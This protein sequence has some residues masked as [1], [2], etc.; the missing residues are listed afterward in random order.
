MR[1]S[2]STC[3]NW[4]KRLKHYGLRN[5][6][7]LFRNLKRDGCFALRLYKNDFHLR[8]NSV[9]FTVFDSIFAGGEYDFDIDFSPE[10]IIDAG[11]YIGASTIYFHH[12]FPD[13][14]ITAVEPEQTNFDLLA[15]N[16]APYKNL[17]LV[18]GAVYGEDTRLK[19][20]DPDADKYAFRVEKTSDSDR[21]VAGYTIDTLMSKY[22]VP[23]IDILKMDIEGAEYHVFNNDDLS[24][25]KKVRV[26]VIE[27]HEYFKPG[28]TELFYARISA[29]HYRKMLR[30]ENII[31]INQG[32]IEG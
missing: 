1:H 14:R 31:I 24:W 4:L 18:H 13:A 9:D 7:L 21:S 12:R 22:Q 29:I 2:I 10:Y 26:L 28:I 8:G 5:T 32:V 16:A 6:I 27:L 30:G 3:N 23:R 11:A 19:I 20:S 15:R 17:T 25:L